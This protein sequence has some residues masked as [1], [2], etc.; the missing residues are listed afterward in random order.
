MTGWYDPRRL[1]SIGI[2]VAEA[3][4]FG[5]MFDRR[6]LMAS[7]DPFDIAY[8]NNNFDFSKPSFQESNGDFWFD[9]VAD[10]GDGWTSTYAV[11]RLLAKQELRVGNQSL[12]Q[13]RVLLFGGDQ[14]YPTA[15]ED[16]YQKKLKAPFDAANKFENKIAPV[17]FYNPKTRCFGNR[18]AFAIPGN[19]DWYDDLTAFTGMFCNKA[20]DREGAV[21]SPGRTVCGRATAQTRSYFALKL[22]NDWWVCAFDAQLEGRIDAP[23][24][25]FFEYVAQ[26]LM[27]AGSNIILSVA[28]PGWAYSQK[29]EAAAGFSNFAFASLIATGALGF[30]DYRP[31]RQHNLRL[32]LTGDSHHYAHFVERAKN[33]NAII[34]YLTCGLGGAFLHPTHWLKNTTPTVRWTAPPPLLPYNSD[35]PVGDHI[36]N[37]SILSNADGTELLFPDRAT[38]RRMTWRNLAFA[39]FNPWFGIL[40]AAVGM[41]ATWLLHFGARVIDNDLA[42][43]VGKGTVSDSIA[44]LLRLLAETPWPWLIIGGIFAALY[45]FADFDEKLGKAVYGGIHATVHL[46]VYFSVLLLAA[47]CLSGSTLAFCLPNKLT[48]LCFSNDLWIILAT[49]ISTFIAAPTIMGVYLLVMLNGFG[50]HWNEAYS[51]LRIADFKGFLRLRITAKGDVE[52]YPIVLDK[53]PRNDSG[54]LDYRLFEGPIV[55]PK[56][57]QR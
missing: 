4:V 53:V 23:Q 13:G 47:H 45:Y 2:R 1:L 16:D 35:N 9:F 12:P 10:T 42:T 14:V 3:T 6:E 57:A 48:G 21:R 46:L 37:F 22:P 50:V 39:W 52:V 44:N 51:S 20:P 8:F 43:Y 49:G 32:V 36:R 24:V 5:K 41:F 7:L 56:V 28:G 30:P 40:M 15:S 33:S 25:R 31:E 55:I 38:S 27:N 29:G 18:Y 34:H 54:E 11:A 19:H 26:R 17:T